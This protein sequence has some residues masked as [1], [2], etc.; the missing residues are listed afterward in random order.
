MVVSRATV[1]II[2]PEGATDFTL[3]LPYDIQRKPDEKH[4]SYLDTIGRPVIVLEKSNLVDWHIQPVEIS[5][6]FKPIY[7]LQEPLLVVGSIFALCLL[8]IGLVRT[9]TSLE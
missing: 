5:Y 8:V 1:K 2:L 7:L 4:F 6:S 3:K 9:K